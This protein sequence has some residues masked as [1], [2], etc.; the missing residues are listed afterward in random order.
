MVN[1]ELAKRLVAAGHE[2]H[3]VVGGFAG[4][5]TEEVRDGFRIT[6]LGNRFTL[7]WRAYRFYSKNLTQWPDLVIDEMNTIPFFAKYY[8]K[9]RNVMLVH[10]LAREIWMYQM[11]APLS[12]V[13]YALE[14][15]YLFL[16]RDREVI[17]VSQSTKND[18]VRYGFSAEKIHI[19]SEGI[20]CAPL[21]SLEGITKYDVPTVLSLGAVRPM[22]RTLDIVR[23]FECLKKSVPAA[24]LII[25]G[26]MSGAYAESVRKAV[27]GSSHKADI[28]LLGRVTPEK[29]FELMRQSHALAVTSVKEG[30]GLVVTEANSQGTP[31]A[32]YDVDGLRDSVRNKET[33]IVA[34]RNT[35]A[36][37]AGA[38]VD[39]LQDK[40]AYEHMRVAGWQWSK[41]ITFDTAHKELETILRT[42]A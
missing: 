8:T 6:R 24:R 19:I 1:E 29:K 26:D 36:G 5:S 25:A 3:F 13:G 40:E 7:Y 2:I 31:A 41:G 35:P 17:T 30:W 42:Y 28:E 38:I 9:Q 16:L 14:P 12:W 23:A 21:E 4:G 20:E 34:L 37:L 27:E 22:K 32:V 15:L 10:Q 39:L 18:L 11:P 33:G